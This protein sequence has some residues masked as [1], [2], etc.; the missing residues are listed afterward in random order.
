MSPPSEQDEDR[1]FEILEHPADV[2]F[3]AYGRTLDELF[4]NSALAMLSLACDLAGIEEQERRDIEASGADTE[5]LLFAWLAEILAVADAERLVFRRVEVV[6]LSATRVR[7]IAHGQ[8]F[9][10]A[11]HRAG[12]AIKAV[13]YHQLRVEQTPAGWQAQV[14][15]DV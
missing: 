14:F 13:T 6:A 11:R 3:R 1:Q 9:D 7:G 10:R 8:A 15:L 4:S 12:T 5:A 2:G